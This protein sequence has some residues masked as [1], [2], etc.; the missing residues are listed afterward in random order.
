[1]KI[2]LTG[3]NGYVS[4]RLLPEL[5]LLGQD[6]SFKIFFLSFFNQSSCSPFPSLP[7]AG[8]CC[9]ELQGWLSPSSTSLPISEAKWNQAKTQ[10]VEQTS[11]LLKRKSYSLYLAFS[12]CDSFSIFLLFYFLSLSV[13][14]KRIL[15]EFGYNA[16]RDI[17]HIV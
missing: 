2:L 4:R 12:V 3:A 14:L 11:S 5:L 13:S 9:P 17:W 1:M 6:F 16:A 7:A 8:T 10:L 15:F